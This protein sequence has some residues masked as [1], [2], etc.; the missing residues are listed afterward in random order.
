MTRSRTE[1]RKAGGD[2]MLAEP[3]CASASEIDPS[4]MV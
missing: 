1:L 3:P 2:C 4:V